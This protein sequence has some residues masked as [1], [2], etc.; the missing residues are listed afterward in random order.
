MILN[1]EELIV[2]L[3]KLI[4]KIVAVIEDLR[5]IHDKVLLANLRR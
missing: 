3:V 2:S 4:P 5:G 1:L